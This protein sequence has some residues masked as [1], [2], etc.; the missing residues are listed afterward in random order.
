M[1]LY[2]CDERY[3]SDR[4]SKYGWTVE[5]ITSFKGLQNFALH[6]YENIFIETAELFD[7]L[8]QTKVVSNGDI[9]AQI[10]QALTGK[11]YN[12]IEDKDIIVRCYNFMLY[13][14]IDKINTALAVSFRTTEKKWYLKDGVNVIENSLIWTNK[15]ATNYITLDKKEFNTNTIPLWSNKDFEE[16]SVIVNTLFYMNAFPDCVVDGVPKR[17]IIDEGCFTNKRTTLSP[18]K[19]K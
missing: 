15:F 9:P 14:P 13:A 6:G 12:V 7:F 1:E 8:S 17:A 16:F 11:N 4:F 18:N 3:I 2:K 10:F 5:N 19:K